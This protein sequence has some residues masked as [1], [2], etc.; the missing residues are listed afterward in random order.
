MSK[1]KQPKKLESPTLGKHPNAHDPSSAKYSHPSWIVGAMDI[2]WEEFGWGK[3]SEHE[4]K[5]IIQPKLRDF[6]SMTWNDITAPDK[7]HNVEKWKLIKEAR[8]RLIKL[9][10]DD[11][12]ELYSLRLGG[13]RRIWGIRAANFLKIIW[14]DPNHLICPSSKRNT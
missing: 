8:D 12:D 1:N 4:L 13:K 14:W 2:E 6:E 10:L 7:S 5:N 9:Q 11:I 3:A